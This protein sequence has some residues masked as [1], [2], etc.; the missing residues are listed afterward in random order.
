M[1]LMS[2]ALRSKGLGRT[3]VFREADE[4]QKVRAVSLGS[5]SEM[6][7]FCIFGVKRREW[8]RIPELATSSTRFGMVNR[9]LF[10]G[11]RGPIQSDWEK[12]CG[13]RKASV[14]NNR[15]LSVEPRTLQTSRSPSSWRRGTPRGAPGVETHTFGEMKIEV[16]YRGDFASSHSSLCRPACL[17]VSD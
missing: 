3:R 5:C 8:S 7:S 2:V 16:M 10:A 9:M 4:K 1:L 12:V 15:R 17:E 6:A 13:E 11:G 14:F